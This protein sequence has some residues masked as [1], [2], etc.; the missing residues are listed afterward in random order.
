M[1]NGKISF[2]VFSQIAEWAHTAPNPFTTWTYFK[3]S[4][5]K[6]VLGKKTYFCKNG[7]TEFCLLCRNNNNN[8]NNGVGK[9]DEGVE[10]DDVES[11]RHATG[12]IIDHCILG[13]AFNT[14]SPHF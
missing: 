9:G 13:Q 5:F 2:I 8:I 7:A 3:V 12:K 1:C 10:G 14:L 11:V 6:Q 4:S